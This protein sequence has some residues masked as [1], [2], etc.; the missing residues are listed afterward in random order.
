MTQP[1]GPDR[2]E[3]ATAAIE[4]LLNLFRFERF[5]YL[6]L[7]GLSALGLAICIV[8]YLFRADGEKALPE[9]IGMFSSSGVIAV[10]I[11]QVLK[12]WSQALAIV[13]RASSGSSSG[14]GQ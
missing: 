8:L 4:R 6:A 14:G 11:G 10:S 12:M 9:V 7:C 1:A 3:V 5:A 2:V 13:E